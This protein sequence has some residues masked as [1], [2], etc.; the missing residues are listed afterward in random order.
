[1]SN[2]IP[3]GNKNDRIATKCERSL[4]GAIKHNDSESRIV[5]LAQR[6]KE[7]KIRACI[8]KRQDEA[9]DKWEESTIDEVIERYRKHRP[10]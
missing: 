3:D 8:A 1:M 4:I 10:Q 6:L 2:Y 7:A 5:V 9:R